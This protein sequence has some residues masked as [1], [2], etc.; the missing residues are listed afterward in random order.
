MVRI[1]SGFGF[2]S[3]YYDITKNSSNSLLSFIYLGH[4]D[5]IKYCNNNE[6]ILE[7]FNIYNCII[8]VNY[9]SNE[10]ENRFHKIDGPIQFHGKK[11]KHGFRIKT[12]LF[13]DDQ[14]QVELNT[15]ITLNDAGIIEET[16]WYNVVPIPEIFDYEMA[17]EEHRSSLSS[18]EIYKQLNNQDNI[19]L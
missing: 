6:N 10:I 19:T 18:M 11:E 1:I 16:K 12:D 8:T 2:E 5:K 13:L 15:L 14:T 9:Y 4:G 3:K 7:S 17:L